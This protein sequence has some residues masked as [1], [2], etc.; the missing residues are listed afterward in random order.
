MSKELDFLVDVL[1]LTRAELVGRIAEQEGEIAC[2]KDVIAALREQ[3][4]NM[5]VVVGYVTR[6]TQRDLCDS[7]TLKFLP[8]RQK[9][10]SERC[11]PIYVIDHLQEQGDE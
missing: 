10:D 9:K 7:N 2:L 4:A 11:V 8:F 5:P 1:S 6:K 3:I